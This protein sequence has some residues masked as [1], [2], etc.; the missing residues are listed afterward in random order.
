MDIELQRQEARNESIYIY[1]EQ[2]FRQS[3]GTAD[4]KKREEEILE[5]ERERRESQQDE[6]VYAA[7]RVPS[8]LFC[9]ISS[10]IIALLAHHRVSNRK[11]GIYR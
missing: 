6:T 5:R 10:I 7:K 1:K 3:S 8:S 2:S 11:E 9:Y 4:G